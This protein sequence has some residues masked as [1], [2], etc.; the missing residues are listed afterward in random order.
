M[1]KY[2][3]ID[4]G[5]TFIKYAVLDEKGDVLEKKK[6]RTPKEKNTF[7]KLLFE[8]ISEFRS[9]IEGVAVCCPGKVNTIDGI[10]YHG[11]NVKYLHEM[12]L[13]Q[14]IQQKFSL[15]AS[16]I[17]DGKA[18]VLAEYWLGNLKG[19][20]SGCAIVLG[21]AIGGGLIVDGK[22][23]SGA[24]YQAGELSFM[25]IMLQ[26]NNDA[27]SVSNIGDQLSAVKF[28]S[29]ASKILSL[30]EPDG[31][32]VF[33]E[34]DKGDKRLIKLLEEY[35]RKLAY[36]ILTIQAVVDVDRIVIG[37]GISEQKSLIHEI[38]NQVEKLK[39]EIPGFASTM[40]TPE[41][42]CCKFKNDANLLGALYHL[43]NSNERNGYDE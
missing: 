14:L 23:L 30:N 13:K 19:S 22:V 33:E 34:I 37:G 28:V 12:P 36:Y 40:T 38:K 20:S 1:T 25:P 16:V 9:R 11:G 43:V 3:G 31:E 8:I 42:F 35:S 39:Y 21:T 4:I 18:V 17:N 29:D 32:I 26:K 6:Q 27:S 15:P 10:V 41:I 5:G 24:H 2:L 7:Q